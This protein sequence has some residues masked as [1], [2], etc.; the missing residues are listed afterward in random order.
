MG[1]GMS[2]SRCS[3]VALLWRSRFIWNGRGVCHE[4]GSLVKKTVNGKRGGRG[5]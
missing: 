3:I 5:A 4:A 2:T 1:L